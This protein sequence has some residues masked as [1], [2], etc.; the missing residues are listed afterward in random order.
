MRITL[1]RQLR[2][3]T[4]CLCSVCVLG[5]ASEI[6]AAEISSLENKSSDLENTLDSI[7]GELLEIGA[8][9]AENELEI[10]AVN[11]DITKTE[12]QLAI[13][14]KNE[15]AYYDEMKIRI[16]YIYEN[17]G[18]PILGLIFSAESLADFVNKVHFVQTL[19]EYDRNMFEE[20]QE[21]RYAIETEEEYLKEQ[22]EACLKLEGELS[23]NREELKAKAASTSADLA[24][25]ETK[26]NQL[27]DEQLAKE[28]AA[29]AKA[30]KEA[31][32]A[33]EAAQTSQNDNK[34]TTGGNNKPSNG[35]SN[36]SSGGNGGYVYPSGDGV[37]TKDKGVNYFNGHRETYYSQRVLPGHGL[38]IPGRHVASDGT[39]RDANGYLCLASSDYP[40]GTVVQTSLG[41]GIVYDTGCASGTID[42]YTD[43]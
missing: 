29:A 30:A 24:A 39:I 33:K 10:E 8:K 23:A 42:I 6:F 37:L 26:I 28:L 15:E 41:P 35:N 11:A 31:E 43:W 2:V 14:R 27:K 18:E 36:G 17:S 40:K 12:E 16:Q 22:Q 20:L 9:I 3:M 32:A 1:K 34:P 19:S 38:N 7:N 21:L 4:A 25:L 13:A 5:S